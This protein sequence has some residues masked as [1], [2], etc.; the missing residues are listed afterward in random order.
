VDLPGAGKRKSAS[1]STVSGARRA[2]WRFLPKS[3]VVVRGSLAIWSPSIA[4]HR[5]K[6]LHSNAA[7]HFLV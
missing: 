5:F 6:S 3:R 1:T 7:G 2:H 4:R